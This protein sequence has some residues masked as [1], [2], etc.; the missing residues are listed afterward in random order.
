MMLAKNYFN[1]FSNGC[2]IA[3]LHGNLD[4]EIYVE[5]PKGFEVYGKMPLICKL[6]KSLYGLKQS[7]KKWNKKFDAFMRS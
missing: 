6:K 7:P 3:F 1:L 2:K 4:E 5:Q